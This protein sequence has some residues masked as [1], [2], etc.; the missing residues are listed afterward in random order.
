M[1]NSQSDLTR[2]K[3]ALERRRT[4]LTEEYE[5]ANEQLGRTL[6]EVNRRRLQRQIEDLERQLKETE[7]KINE[8]EQKARAAS[9][10][11]SDLDSMAG[12][13]ERKRLFISY[14]R[15]VEPDEIVAIQLCHAFQP[16]YEVFIDQAM[17]AGTRWAERIKT[18]LG[19]SDFLITFLSAESIHSQMLQEELELAHRLAQEHGG[20]PT[21]LPVRLAYREPF[22]YPLN[23]YL[24]PINWAFWRDQRDTARLIS[25]LKIAISGGDLPVTAKLKP[26][27]VRAGLP[28]PF[29]QPLASAQP[30]QLEMPEGTMEAQSTFYVERFGDRI[31]LEALKREGVTVTIKAPRQMG[32]SSLL[33][34]AMNT[35]AQAGKRV[36]FLDF[37]LFD[38][39]A[40]SDATIFFRQFCAWLTAELGLANRLDDYWQMPLGNPHRCTSY[41]GRYLLPELN[42]PLVLAMDEVDSIFGAD[43]RSDFFGMLRHWH[44]D[45][46]RD[47]TWKR[48]DLVLV[49]STE[50]YLL[51]ENLNQSP[52]N[53]G[54]VIELADF[55]R[56]QLADLNRRHGSPLTPLQEEQL[57]NLL[58]GHPYLTRRALYLAASQRLSVKEIFA[59]A[60]DDRGPF[61]DHLRYH[62]FRLHGQEELIQGLRQALRHH[63]CPNERIFFRLRGAGLVRREG[64]AVLPRCQLYAQYF[65]ERL[66]G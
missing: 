49:T 33:M 5:A 65:K 32:K 1:S 48:L 57:M 19:R 40:L 28:P 6:N 7:Q 21:I 53:V 62:S 15:D 20:R 50:P 24:D 23:I 63:T 30:I 34:R 26:H 29:P 3:Q 66:D 4:D 18:E 8:V 10:P 22:Q 58:N 52:F 46:G 38:Q 55:T 61:G 36:A 11:V 64:Q 2:Q 14:K 60:T 35:A 42:R 31:A 25:E 39:A 44:N 37:Q 27:I 9:T 12:T 16:E 56:E 43:F 47:P 17:P 45:R 54:E 51:I 13:P 59:Q 41:L